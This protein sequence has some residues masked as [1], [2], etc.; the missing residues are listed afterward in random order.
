MSVVTENRP[1]QP[2]PTACPFCQS[3]QIASAG[4]TVSDASYWRCATCGQIWNPTR[5]RVPSRWR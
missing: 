2:A 3:A 1:E 4:K 5:L